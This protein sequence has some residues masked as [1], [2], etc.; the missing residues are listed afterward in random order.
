MLSVA[1]IMALV[2]AA[3]CDGDS[4]SSSSESDTSMT[5][6]AGDA[7]GDVDEVLDDVE[8]DAGEECTPS[9]LEVCDTRDNDCDGE[10]DEEVCV[11][12]SC[13]WAPDAARAFPLRGIDWRE[14][15]ESYAYNT[16]DDHMAI[17]AASSRDEL[18][19]HTMNADGDYAS[20]PILSLT[21]EVKDA[22]W[23]GGEYVVVHEGM[24][25]RVDAEG[26][27]LGEGTPWNPRAIDV[28]TAVHQG[29]L[30]RFWSELVDGD[31]PNEREVFYQTFDGDLRPTMEPL[32]LTQNEVSDRVFSH[33]DSV[34]FRG[35]QVGFVHHQSLDADQ[36]LVARP[37][38]TIL[39]EGEVVAQTLISSEPEPGELVR[40]MSRA[41]I[42][43]S[44]EGWTVCES[45]LGPNSVSCTTLDTQASLESARGSSIA[46]EGVCS[47]NLTSSSE[48]API[49]VLDRASGESIGSTEVYQSLAFEVGVEDP[50]PVVVGEFPPLFDY[51]PS[52]AWML[53]A[54]PGR[55]FRAPMFLLNAPASQRQLGVQW[56]GCGD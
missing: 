17:F 25:Y 4:S 30:H 40:F 19:I 56:F 18:V 54:G 23:V 46:C 45:S 39:E 12:E 43:A 49:V 51:Q 21:G 52:A 24:V 32:R 3:A 16:R 55:W 42:A 29:E 9:G 34:A 7:S 11:C 50:Q 38:L 44:G 48:C 8:E 37:L 36:P 33:A 27:V 26:Q 1:T 2:F 20:F 28:L 14:G 41:A 13:A 5:E 47:W 22:V 6:D 35:A 10:V 31:T 15:G 53:P